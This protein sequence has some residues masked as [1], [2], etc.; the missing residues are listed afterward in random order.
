MWKINVEIINTY[1]LL[2]VEKRCGSTF[3]GLLKVFVK[4]SNQHFVHIKTLKPT[5]F[6]MK[7]ERACDSYGF[8]AKDLTWVEN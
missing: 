7:K 6:S 3:L 1:F 4:T 5:S 2:V 8:K